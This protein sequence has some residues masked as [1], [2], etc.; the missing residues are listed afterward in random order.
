[1]SEQKYSNEKM[2]NNNNQVFYKNHTHLN[3]LDGIK[4][5]KGGYTK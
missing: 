1:M 5:L 3:L 2:E 4:S